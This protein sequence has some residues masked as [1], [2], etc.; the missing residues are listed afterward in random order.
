MSDQNLKAA[1]IGLQLLSGLADNIVFAAAF[2]HHTVKDVPFEE[3]ID[4]AL[5]CLMHTKK[6]IPEF[7]KEHRENN[8]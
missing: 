5:K 6:R 8:G 4:H 7:V 2:H 1:S 3:A